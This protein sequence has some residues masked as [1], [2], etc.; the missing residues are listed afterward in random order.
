VRKLQVRWMIE[1]PG[2]WV[3]RRATIPLPSLLTVLLALS[4]ALYV[5]ELASGFGNGRART[6]PIL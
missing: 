2:G 4:V 3:E 1:G 6:G 5:W